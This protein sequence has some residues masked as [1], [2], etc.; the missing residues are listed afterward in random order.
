QLNESFA[1]RHL[2]RRG[3]TGV[4]LLPEDGRRVPDI[5]YR[6]GRRIKH[7]EV[8]TISISDD[9]ISRRESSEVFSNVY[10]RLQQGFFKKLASDIV[11]AKTQIVERGTGGLVYV[12]VV[13]DDIALDYYQSYR[14]ALAAFASVNGID[15]VHIKVG[16]R[17]NRRMRLA[18]ASR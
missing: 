2:V 9:E 6:H 16:L 17:F 11:A 10:V 14:R 1:Y 15:D 4:R 13:W 12:V 7:C 3:F 18:G 8:K 5:R